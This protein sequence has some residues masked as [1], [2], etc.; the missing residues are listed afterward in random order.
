VGQCGMGNI[1]GYEAGWEVSYVRTCNLMVMC[2]SRHTERG[3]R[4]SGGGQLA[5]ELVG[6]DHRRARLGASVFGSPG[7]GL[8][9]PLLSLESSGVVRLL[10]D[11]GCDVC[12][13]M[14]HVVGCQPAI[15]GEPSRDLTWQDCRCVAPCDRKVRHDRGPEGLCL[16]GQA[17]PW[18]DKAAPSAWFAK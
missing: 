7:D 5:I 14:R 4:R 6:S 13:D 18:L 11:E 8:L 10:R 12:L 1:G 2:H 17:F 9:H 15:C 16:R 3:R